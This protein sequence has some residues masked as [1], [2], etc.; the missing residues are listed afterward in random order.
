MSNLVFKDNL[1]PSERKLVEHLFRM[2]P[3]KPLVAWLLWLCT[4]IFGGHRFYLKD[5]IG[6]TIVL[7]LS[8]LTAASYFYIARA[9]P[10]L[11]FIPF[12][13]A[14]GC[15][16]LL[17]LIDACTLFSKTHRTNNQI[18]AQIIIQVANMSKR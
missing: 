8:A 12:Y 14:G 10:T 4:G 18:E 17:L 3:K 15:L 11:G 7:C 6:G 9:V 2:R 16:A 5:P 1:S 13:A